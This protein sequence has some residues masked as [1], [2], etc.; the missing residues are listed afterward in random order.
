MTR[1]LE[2]TLVADFSWLAGR[3][4]TIDEHENVLALIVFLGQHPQPHLM[5][6]GWMQAA[7][8][9]LTFAIG[10]AAMAAGAWRIR[11]SLSLSW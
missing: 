5:L 10:L 9:A 1:S 11:V 4:W 2:E 7:P 8:A 3:R 6:L